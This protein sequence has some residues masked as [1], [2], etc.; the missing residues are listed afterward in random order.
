MFLSFVALLSFIAV[1]TYA[2]CPIAIE[3]GSFHVCVLTTS[4]LFCHG[5]GE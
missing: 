2:F 4:E 3:A 1:G 5:L